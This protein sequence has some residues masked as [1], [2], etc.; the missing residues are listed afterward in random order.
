MYTSEDGC[1]SGSCPSWVEHFE[2]LCS[3]EDLSIEEL[4]RMTEGEGI[5]LNDL[6]NSSCLHRVCMNEL[7]TFE[8]VE[9]LMDL[10]PQ[11]INHCM[12][13]TDDYPDVFVAYPLHLACYNEKC[14]NE[15]IELLLEKG[16][17]YILARI[18]YIDI[19]WTKSDVYVNDDEGSGGTPLHFYLSRTSNITVSIISKMLMRWPHALVSIDDKTMCT[20]L[21]ILMHNKNIGEAFDVVEYIVETNPSSLQM[22]DKYDQ[23][24][25]H[26]ACTKRYITARTVKLLLN[27]WNGAVYERDISN[28]L[29]VHCLCDKK[30]RGEEIDDEVAT[31]ILKLLLDAQPDL[32]TKTT[33]FD[34]ENQEQLPL[35]IAA[36]NKS[37]AFCKVL[38]DAYPESVKIRGIGDGCLPFHLACNNGQLETVEYLFG[39][40]PESLHLRNNKGHLPIHEAVHH[41]PEDHAIDIIKFLLRHDPECISKPTTGEYRTWPLH[42][43]CG[44]F[45]ESNVTELLFDIYPEAILL[46]NDQEDLPIDIVRMNLNALHINP[47]TG[48]VYNKVLYRRMEYIIS[49]VLAQMNHA[50]K[51]QDADATRT[52]DFAGSLPLH[53]A[54]QG[55]APLGAIKLLVNGN[56]DAINIPDRSGMLPLNIACQFST[57]GVVKYLIQLSP[58]RL[59][60]C[61]VNNNF[62]LHHACRGGNCEVISYLL[63]TPMSSASVSERNVDGMIP[64][65]LFCDCEFVKGRWCECEGETPEYTET[66]WRLLT[67]YPETVLNW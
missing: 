50:R 38:V 6:L 5:S 35:H 43:V 57:V 17:E 30:E 37:Q 32:V 19:D 67:A 11:A 9:Y 13:I 62:P 18:C 27:G 29:P 64:I 56:T 52:S 15:V 41:I 33:D 60:A 40:Y 21:H 42:L 34:F 8:M 26:I 51:A 1:S 59:N 4:R 63:E 24:P 39:L 31:D 47:E 14:P 66:I 53:N 65:H 55:R 22:K 16:G 48:E 44:T 23:T 2:E 12:D 3:S 46:R 54:I 7:V 28:L 45:D 49:F 10:Y 36:N 25:L 58:G 61:D 20:P